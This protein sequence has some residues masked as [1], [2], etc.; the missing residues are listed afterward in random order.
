MSGCLTKQDQ[1][2]RLLNHVNRYQNVYN[3][4]FEY[5]KPGS[6]TGSINTF[7]LDPIQTGNFNLAGTSSYGIG[8][9][10]FKIF[11]GYTYSNGLALSSTGRQSS[12]ELNPE[13]FV[14][15]TRSLSALVI[16][17]NNIAEWRIPISLSATSNTTPALQVSQFGTAPAIRVNAGTTPFIV[18]ASG[19]VGIGTDSP[20]SML[21]LKTTGPAEIIL[22]ADTD[23]AN[24]SDNARI[25]F[26]QG[27]SA[28]QGRVGYVA[29]DNV[30]EVVNAFND[31]LS[32]KTADTEKVIIKNNGNVGINLP[33]PNEKLTVVGNISAEGT[34]IYRSTS[35][36]QVNLRLQRSASS[37]RSQFTL[38]TE[39]G[40]EIW[41]FG[42]TGPGLSSF[43][44]YN[45][46]ANALSIDY[47]SGNVSVGGSGIV[48]TKFVVANISAG[49]NSTWQGGTD[50]I[51]LY[52]T[53]TA[54]SEP[55]IVFQEVNTNVGAK[56]GVKNT[57][58][59]AYDILFA[60]RNTSA[61]DSDI[62]EK[63]RITNAGRVGINVSAP[64]C[65]VHLRQDNNVLFGV[66]LL[67]SEVNKGS[68]FYG[69]K[70]CFDKVSVT[71]AK[72][73]AGVK[74]GSGVDDFVISYNASTTSAG[75]IKLALDTTGNLT[76]DGSDATKD[77]GSSTWITTSDQ[78]I[79]KDIQIADIDRCYEIVK[80]LPLKRYT[81]KD[82]IYSEQQVKD[83]S[84]IGWIAQDVRTVFPKAVT[85]IEKTFQPSSNADEVTFEDL[86]TLNV[87]QVYAAMYGAV[88]KLITVVENL[89][90]RVQ[91]LE[92]S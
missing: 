34:G 69:P 26:K 30:F 28:V 65:Q 56:I 79:K 27:G 76:I 85:Q 8:K 32:F 46:T 53:N 12:I 49:V 89:E 47:A 48:D 35:A 39:S 25:L 74:D 1:I 5:F 59:G 66:S 83:R 15:R 52:T 67:L 84:R 78:R 70:I 17:S 2:D 44:F 40:G 51:K 58:N 37:G 43:N 23:N 41:R 86:N 16:G 21:H 81:W 73:T 14:L 75:T 4:W 19:N 71:N 88:Q 20:E 87:D 45:N 24:E 33:M 29:G 22:E 36:T 10:D 38:E 7:E 31:D 64:S 57:G 6:S 9:N 82:E 91:N 63:M 54:Y 80:T 11:T 42:C 68:T 90:A 60:N 61:V 77:G 62:T 3:D 50:Y 72:W 18:N 92:N 13:Y 55:A